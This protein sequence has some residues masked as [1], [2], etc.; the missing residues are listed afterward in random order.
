MDFLSKLFGGIT[1]LFGGGGNSQH[2]TQPM[3]MGGGGNPMGGIAGLFNQHPIASGLGLMGAGQLFGGHTK[4]PNFNTPDV[5]NLR[6]FSSNPPA[7]P[8]N[9]QDEINKS[10]G[11]NEEEQLRNLRNV[12]KNARPGTD[13]TTD[14][15]YQRDASNL[16]RTLASNRANAMIDP[17]LKY[18]EPQQ[19]NLTNLA[20]AS[21]NEQVLQQAMKA[22]KQQ[23]IKDLFGQTG[24]LFVQKGLWPDLFKVQ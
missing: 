2:A 12:Y 6:N 4:A 1:S 11:I 15:A 21:I 9:M 23:S 16:Q 5:Q 22:Q 13:Y 19:Q 7:L 18:L 3:G 17:T 8:Q 10:L 20:D 24:G 14:S